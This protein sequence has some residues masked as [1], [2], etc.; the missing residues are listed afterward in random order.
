MK[1]VYVYVPYR[2]P[3]AKPQ[4]SIATRTIGRRAF[5]LSGLLNHLRLSRKYVSVNLVPKAAVCGRRYSRA[6]QGCAG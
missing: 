2:F 4:M 1:C 3:F 6:S 5:L